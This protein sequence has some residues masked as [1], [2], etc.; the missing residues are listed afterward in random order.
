MPRVWKRI[1]CW[2]LRNGLIFS[3]SGGKPAVVE[4]ARRY[5]LG[6]EFRA[7]VGNRGRSGVPRL[8][9]AGRHVARPLSRLSRAARSALLNRIGYNFR[10]MTASG[11]AWP[12]VDI[13]VKYVKTT[14][15]GQRLA[16]RARSRSTR[17][18]SRLP[19]RLRTVIGRRRH[20][21]QH[22]ASRRRASARRDVFRFAAGAPRQSSVCCA[23]RGRPSSL[24]TLYLN[25][26]ESS[27]RSAPAKMRCLE[28]ARRRPH[29]HGAI[30]RP[31][32][33]APTMVGPCAQ[34][35]AGRRCR[36]SPSST[37]A[38]I[39]C[40]RARSM[41]SASPSPNCAPSSGPRR[42]AVVLGTS[43]SGIAAG[44]EAAATLAREGRMPSTITIGNK[45]LARPRNSRRVFALDR[46]TLHD[47][48]RVLVVGEGVRVGRAVDRRR[49]LRRRDRRR[50]RQLVPA[51]AERLRCARV[52]RAGSLQSVQRQP[53]RASTSAKARA[54]SS[55]RGGRAPIRLC[56]VGES[57]DGYHISAPDP[58][59]RGA[60]A[61][62]RAALARRRRAPRDVGYVNLHGTA[63]PKN[64]EMESAVM[65]RVFGLD[66]PCS[67]TK[68]LMGHTLG[69]AGA[70]ELGLC[71]LL[72]SDANAARRLARHGW[73]GVRDPRLP[74]INLVGAD[75]AV[76]ARR[77][78]LELVR[79]RRQQRGDRHR[80]GVM[81]SSS[82]P[83]GELLPHGPEMTLIDRLSEYSPQRSVATVTITRSQ[84]LRR[85]RRRTGLG[86][87]R[88]HGADDRRACGL[89]GAAARPAAGDRFLARHARYR[90]DVGVFP[91][92]ATL[93]ISVEPL[94]ADAEA[95]SVSM[96][97]RH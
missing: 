89:R 51:D 97:D 63:T 22:D 78:R 57:S 72:L 29:G 67:S 23:C 17:I 46:S 79:V 55:C 25:D 52:A 56:G 71:W 69:A 74:P 7:A 26:R 19:T 73:D 8:R 49:A 21:G 15:F 58:S 12:I 34:R 27:A 77:V 3:T 24:V 65:A 83:I 96:R 45:R 18:G 41:R 53:A 91:L 47:L 20:Q 75:A 50:R 13:R 88:V 30:R 86:R 66:V 43:T 87:H 62:I 39:V 60:E 33:G 61:A 38:T 59:G 64:D 76:R 40:W 48:D 16:V 2:P 1:A 54:C 5:G 85:S 68:S 94:V 80:Q 32:D 36:R 11:Y 14:T 28:T 31:A 42:I 81:D 95:R 35:A 44:E 9:P 84:P 92:G 10:Q 4:A 90:S 93:T 70:Q 6:V 37:A 82:V